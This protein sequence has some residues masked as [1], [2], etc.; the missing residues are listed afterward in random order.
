M[1]SL[2]SERA[3][4]KVNLTL[5]V[6]GRR[7]D[8]YHELESLVAF[9]R[10]VADM[11]TLVP[12]LSRVVTTSGPF[13]GSIAGENLVA[14]TLELIAQAA[15]HLTL[16]AVQLEKNLPIAAG[17]GGGS[18]DAAAVMRAVMRANPTA[19]S[20][21]NWM[22]IA[23]R[24]GADVPVCLTSTAQIMTGVGEKLTAVPKLPELS[25]VLVNPLVPVQADKTAQVFRAL[26][27][28]PVDEVSS[29]ASSPMQFF[30]R[31]A[32][33]AHMRACGN[34][35]LVPARS[36]V[37]AIDAVLA[38]LNATPGCELAQLSGGGPTCF[39]VFADMA[40]AEAAAA[41]LRAD[42]AGWWVRATGLG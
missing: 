25:V 3:S 22:A 30:G 32:L 15:P 20:Q 21:V 16:G 10:D 18:A 9:A 5:R 2:V 40:A 28:Q 29:A 19:V 31:A 36:V 38:A 6:L 24:L 39:G 27:T 14:V 33:V 12:G 8:G 23:A 13:A 35:L 26:K 4:P 37:P 17:I 11:V 7:L 1:T 42:Y 41:R 34:D